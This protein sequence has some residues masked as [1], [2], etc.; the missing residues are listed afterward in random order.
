MKVG[1]MQAIGISRT[2]IQ[3]QLGASPAELRRAYERL[4][5]VAHTLDRPDAP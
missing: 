5:R 2:E 1:T 4:E 3:R